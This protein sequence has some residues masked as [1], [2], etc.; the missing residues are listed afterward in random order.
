[1]C[2]GNCARQV[3]TSVPLQQNAVE[4]LIGHRLAGSRSSRTR[5]SVGSLLSNSAG[6]RPAVRLISLRD[7]TQM[8]PYLA[9]NRYICGCSRD[10][11]VSTFR[12]RSANSV[13]CADESAVV[14]GELDRCDCPSS[15]ARACDVAWVSSRPD[16]SPSPTITASRPSTRRRQADTGWSDAVRGRRTGPRRRDLLGR[17]WLSPCRVRRRRPAASGRSPR[18]T[19]N[20]P[21]AAPIPSR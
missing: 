7:Q 15:S 12:R 13:G 21:H 11:V 6:G 20:F 17:L 16:S 10:Q 4:R 3:C 9:T 19:M 14:A 5:R 2:R 18:W 1:M 8:C